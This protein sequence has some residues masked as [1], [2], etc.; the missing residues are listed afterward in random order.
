MQRKTEEEQLYPEV[1]SCDST[2][3]LSIQRFFV[4]PTKE[5]TELNLRKTRKHIYIALIDALLNI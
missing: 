4:K 5:H 2:E 3:T 1:G